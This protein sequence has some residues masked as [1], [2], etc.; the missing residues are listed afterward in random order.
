MKLSKSFDKNSIPVV[1]AADN[2][3][4]PFF[5]ACLISLVE[6]SSA[7]NNYDIVVLNKDISVTN[8]NG[9]QIIVEDHQNISLRFYDVSKV[10][11]DY[12]LQAKEHITIETFFRLIIQD[13]LPDYEKVIYLD[14][15]LIIRCDIADLYKTDIKDYMIAAVRDVDFLG[16][17]N[18]G[19]DSS[20]EYATSI[21]K[22]RNPNSYFQAG[23]LLIN[24]NEMRKTYSVNEWLEIAQ[25]PYRYS[26]QDILNVNCEGKVQYLDMSWNVLTD[27]DCIRTQIIS[28]APEDV[29]KTYYS[30]RINPKIVHFAGFVKPWNKPESDYAY[31]FW[32]YARK[33]PYYEEMLTGLIKNICKEGVKKESE[34]FRLGEELKKSIIRTSKKMTTSSRKAYQ[35]IFR[36]H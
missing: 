5:S 14:S 2:K 22:M 24:E 15:D 35:S 7:G 4:V 8:Q 11:Q 30:A 12:N 3:Y 34:N 28:Y 9:L 6:N 31:L 10:I 17:I 27:C 32:N 21:L 1:F 26:D 19:N 25:F 36:K 13:V 16:Q 18:G 23:V 20:Y 29:K 33:S